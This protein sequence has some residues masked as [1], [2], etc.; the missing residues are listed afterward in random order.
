[1]TWWQEAEADRSDSVCTQKRNEE[2]G[3]GKEKEE[4]QELLRRG[5][6]KGCGGQEE[7][8]INR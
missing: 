3:Y 8:K 5:A 2:R 1:M 6:E 7:D 4:K